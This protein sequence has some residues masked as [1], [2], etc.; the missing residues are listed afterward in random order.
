MILRFCYPRKFCYLTTTVPFHDSVA[1]FC[2]PRKFCY[3]TTIV[4]H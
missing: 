4:I 2:Y 1:E 3:L